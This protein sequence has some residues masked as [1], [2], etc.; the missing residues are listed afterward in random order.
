MLRFER[1]PTHHKSPNGY[2]WYVKCFSYNSEALS[3]SVNLSPFADIE[4][5]HT[6]SLTTFRNIQPSLKIGSSFEKVRMLETIFA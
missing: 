3:Y 1:A 5:K 2:I 6:D 4:I